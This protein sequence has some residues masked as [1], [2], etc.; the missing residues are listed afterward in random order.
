MQNEVDLDGVPTL[1]LETAE[2]RGPWRLWLTG[3]NFALNAKLRV[4]EALTIGSREAAR[5]VVPDPA[6]SACHA[7]V[8][9]GPEGILVE[10]LGSK[11]GVF[12]GSARV[13]RATLRGGCGEFV[14]GRTSVRVE[15]WTEAPAEGSAL[16]PGL[17]GSSAPMRR[18]AEE[19]RR[20]AVLEAPVLL[21]GESGTGKDVVARAIHLLSGRR[22]RYV[23]LNAG[24]LSESLADSELFGHCRGAFTGA[25]QAR[26]GAFEQAD[27]GTLFLDE[28]AD[29]APSIQVKLLRTIED[30]EVRQLGGSSA[31]RVRARLVAATWA[32][33]PQRIAEGTF[34]A[35]LYHRISTF[36]VRLPP[37]RQRKSD[38]PALAAA[39]L[40]TKRSEIG[41]RRLSAA[42][43]ESLSTYTFPGNV[44]E[45]F[46]VVYRA[47]ALCRHAEI[48]PEDI[49]AALPVLPAGEAKSARL[50]ARQLLHVH[51]GNVSA[52]ARSA[53]VAR[54]TFRSWL[55][56]QPVAAPP[57]PL[58]RS[59]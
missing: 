16:L 29:L 10:D 26:S 11:N 55:K 23:P 13:A 52:A 48:G 45:L 58:Q 38:I 44:R 18:L 24:A 47:A 41:Q 49:E 1:E 28:I 34:R 5:V 9:A 21:L 56:R 22:G 4:G 46:S 35:D 54:S 8:S 17:I 15:P 30:G 53:R 19:V 32:Q 33:L 12:V 43:L 20:V 6:V 36:V 51:G 59:E 31:L 2:G 7:R 37:L 3:S 27:R 57:G 50:D 42:A 25:V 39:V 14:L 40:E